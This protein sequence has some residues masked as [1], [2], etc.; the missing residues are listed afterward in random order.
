MTRRRSS[1]PDRKRARTGALRFIVFCLAGFLGSGAIT[2]S[3]S[4]QES[5]AAQDRAE[6]DITDSAR[7]ERQVRALQQDLGLLSLDLEAARRERDAAEASFAE[8]KEAL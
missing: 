5:A 7:L 8:A 1:R 4:D 6:S 3:Y 2:Q